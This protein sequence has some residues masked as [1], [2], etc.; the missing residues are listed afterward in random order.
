MW[1]DCL[2]YSLACCGNTDG[3]HG[4]QRVGGRPGMLITWADC[5]VYSVMAEGPACLVHVDGLHG[6][7]HA[8]GRLAGFRNKPECARW[9]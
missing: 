9:T 2:M 6:N 8:G 5:L 1:T 7:W 4:I 3:L